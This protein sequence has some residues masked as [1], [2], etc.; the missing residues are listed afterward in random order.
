MFRELKRKEELSKCRFNDRREQMR[1]LQVRSSPRGKNFPR[2]TC[3]SG[4][5]KRIEKG[6]LYERKDDRGIEPSGKREDEWKRADKKS[7]KKRDLPRLCLAFIL[8]LHDTGT[9]RPLDR[10]L[11]RRHRDVYIARTA[12]IERSASFERRPRLFEKGKD[13]FFSTSAISSFTRS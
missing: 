9:R 3:I 6:E 10:C 4:R 5:G 7:C 1:K 8:S 11:F 2:V 13:L 12:G